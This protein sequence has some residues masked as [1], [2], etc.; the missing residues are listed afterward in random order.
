MTTTEASIRV[1]MSACFLLILKMERH[2]SMRQMRMSGKIC[3]SF[4][5]ILQ[6]TCQKQECAAAKAPISC[7]STGQHIFQVVTS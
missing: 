6:S 7:G 3:V 5:T 2:G 1:C 4:A